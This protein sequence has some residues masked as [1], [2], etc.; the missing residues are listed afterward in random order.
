MHWGEVAQARNRFGRTVSPVSIQHN[1]QRNNPG[2]DSTDVVEY[3]AAALLDLHPL[4]QFFRIHGDD[5]T[6]FHLDAGQV[7]KLVQQSIHGLAGTADDMGQ[8]FLRQFQA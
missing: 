7:D 1:P 5:L 4:T 3:L 2:D 8:L 6:S